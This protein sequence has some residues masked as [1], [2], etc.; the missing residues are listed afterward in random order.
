MRVT[1][2]NGW[3]ERSGRSL[4]VYEVK[5]DGWVAAE[6]SDGEP[7]DA[8]IMRDFSG[9]KSIPELMKRAYEAG[10]R[11]EEFEITSEEYVDPFEDN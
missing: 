6:F 2:S 5:I 11:G 7:E 10:K 8:N 3:I 9:V 1:E 4:E